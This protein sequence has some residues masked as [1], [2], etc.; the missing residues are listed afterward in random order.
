MFKRAVANMVS[1]F[2]Q[3]FSSDLFQT[4]KAQTYN[5]FDI[6]LVYDCVMIIEL[7][8]KGIYEDSRIV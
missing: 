4:C 2:D 8:K 6:L 5:W 1:A 7:F 3:F